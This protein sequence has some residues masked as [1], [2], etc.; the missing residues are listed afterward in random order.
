[1]KTHSNL[2]SSQSSII[3]STNIFILSENVSS[4]EKK[5]MH[6][7]A[8][9]IAFLPLSDTYGW[10]SVCR[11]TGTLVIDRR[12]RNT[13]YGIYLTTFH[14]IKKQKENVSNSM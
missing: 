14:L 7:L 6:I 11:D 10:S 3:A 8:K 13:A 1:M 9:H 2:S 4:L 5:V 12:L